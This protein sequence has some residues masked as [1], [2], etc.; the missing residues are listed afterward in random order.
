MILALH[1]TKKANHFNISQ[2]II[3]QIYTIFFEWINH[4]HTHT[5]HTHNPAPQPKSG[6]T[7]PYVFDITNQK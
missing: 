5:P 6:V 3:F 7:Q 1:K 4:V 2:S